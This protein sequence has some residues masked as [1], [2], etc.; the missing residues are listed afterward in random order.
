MGKCAQAARIELDHEM[1]ALR[2]DMKRRLAQQ[3]SGLQKR[4]DDLTAALQDA[5]QRLQAEQRDHGATEARRAETG[6]KLAAAQSKLRVLQEKHALVLS[7]HQGCGP[8]AAEL[9]ARLARAV[10]DGEDQIR[11]FSEERGRLEAR[12]AELERE[13]AALDGGNKFRKFVELKHEK[14]SLE[15]ELNQIKSSNN[16][17]GVVG[18]GGSGGSNNFPDQRS[19]FSGSNGAS[20]ASA[21]SQAAAAKNSARRL[22]GAAQRQ[23]PQGSSNNNPAS[24]SNERRRGVPPTNGRSLGNNGSGNN[25]NNRNVRSSSF[26]KDRQQQQKPPPA[27]PTAA[28]IPPLLSSALNHDQQQTLTVNVP[29]ARGSVSLTPRSAR[30]RPTGNSDEPPPPSSGRQQASTTTALHQTESRQGGRPQAVAVG[31]RQLGSF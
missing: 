1:V 21:F 28:V 4:V 25:E 27:A 5:M 7:E 6:E 17:S 30:H 22:K 8:R 31:R 14:R 2:E 19:N 20:A 16:N 3:G 11:R 13:L 29:S 26:D 23:R 24:A 12:I 10:A 9:S 15:Q 18:G